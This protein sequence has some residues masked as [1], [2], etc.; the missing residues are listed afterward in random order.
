MKTAAPPVV[1]SDS[2]CSYV[3]ALRRDAPII[4]LISVFIRWFQMHA[5]FPEL[6]LSRLETCWCDY[7]LR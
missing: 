7:Y 6:E 2:T 5:R 3:A 4:R 1:L